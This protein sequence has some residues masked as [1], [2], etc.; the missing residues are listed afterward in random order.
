MKHFNLKTGLVAG[1]LSFSAFVPMV[2][3]AEETPD[4]EKENR[5]VITTDSVDGQWEMILLTGYLSP[6]D[7]RC[8]ADWNNDGEYQE[9]EKI[10]CSFETIKHQVT[11]PTVTLYGKFKYFLCVRKGLSKVDLTKCP[12]IS[13]LNL[14]RN[15]LKE[16][17]FSQQTDLHYL[18]IGVNQLNKLTVMKKWTGLR[19]I[20]CM[21]NRI[22]AQEMQAIAD[23][24]YDRSAV[25]EN[26]AGE[27]CVVDGRPDVEHNVCTKATVDAFKAKKW[28]VTY[29]RNYED[30][31]AFPEDY[32]GSS[33]GVNSVL[34]SNLLVNVTGDVL[35][36]Q[37]LKFGEAVEV[38]DLNGR[39]VA[40]A[41][42]MGNEVNMPLNGMTK[43]CYVVKVGTMAKKF[44]ITR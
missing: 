4:L 12:M 3:Q 27:I 41:G 36:V 31:D 6:D 39:R 43:G 7:G 17:D 9:G 13:S 14:T 23:S 29:Y 34:D 30:E 35:S 26:P 28:D 40:L 44:V 32:E 37:G 18:Y 38:F 8:W 24:V 10:V 33:S 1:L 2:A 22:S 19:Q 42:S 15:N 5:I 11:S 21:L 20:E 16:I 25:A